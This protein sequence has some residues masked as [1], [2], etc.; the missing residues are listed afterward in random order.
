MYVLRVCC[1]ANYR[2]MMNWQ[3][4]LFRATDVGVLLPNTA[5][6]RPSMTRRSQLQHRTHIVAVSDDATIRVKDD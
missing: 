5:V 1:V 3:I 4:V 2:A 6:V